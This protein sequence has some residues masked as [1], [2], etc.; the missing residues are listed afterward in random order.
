MTLETYVKIISKRLKC[1]A[2]RK[3]EIKKQLLSDIRIQLD[4]GKTSE[5]IISEMGIPAEI[6]ADF[7][8]QFPPE[9]K[10]KYAFRKKLRIL[11]AVLLVLLAAAGLIYWYLPKS[12]E[13]GAKGNLDAVTAETRAKEV[14]LLLNS[15]D[16]DTLKT[17]ATAQME[18][19]LDADYFDAARK[20]ISGDWGSFE[21]FGSAYVYGIRQMNNRYAY[22]E[23]SAIYEHVS[24]T[25]TIILDTQEKIAGIYMK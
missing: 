19:Y 24:V 22:V 10:K 7:N 13:L 14:I 15:Q 20:Q 21:K 5:E 9:E 17:N 23:I 12:C 4:Q 2:S 6:A 25:Y 11:G 16:Y 8:D 1:T 3:K 18:P